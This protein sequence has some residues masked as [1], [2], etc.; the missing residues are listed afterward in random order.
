MQ[1]IGFNLTKIHGEK[2]PS[3]SRAGVNNNIDF[4]NVEKDTVS[5]LKDTEALKISFKYSLL[6]GDVEKPELTKEKDRQAEIAF[7]GFLVLSATPEEA[8]EFHT[9]WK[10]KA[11]PKNAVAPLYNFILRKCSSKAIIL[12]E[13]LSLPSPYLKIPQLRPKE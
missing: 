7:E 4:S 11:V 9:S 13:D 1:I 8:K 5:L 2:K 12:Q 6:Y 3:F 10:K